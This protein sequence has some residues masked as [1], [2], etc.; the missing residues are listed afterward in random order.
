MRRLLENESSKLEHLQFLLDCGHYSI[1]TLPTKM[2]TNLK[3]FSLFTLR[4]F[5]ED[6]SNLLSIIA[7]DCKD[8][9]VL[10]L[11]IHPFDTITPNMIMAIGKIKRFFK[12]IN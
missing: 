9:K 5:D 10:H 11:E 12:E 7:R 1:G 4:K 2:P 3:S 6:S 8:L